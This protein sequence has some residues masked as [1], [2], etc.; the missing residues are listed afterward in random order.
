M[1]HSQ[2][3]ST[4]LFI[5]RHAWLNLWDK[6]MTTGRINQVTTSLHSLFK[7]SNSTLTN[8]GLFPSTG[9]FRSEI[10]W[11]W[12]NSLRTTPPRESFINGSAH[13]NQPCHRSR[14]FHIH[15]SPSSALHGTED[16]GLRRRLPATS[17]WITSYKHSHGGSPSEWW[18]TGLAYIGKSSTAF[19]TFQA[20]VTKGQC[21]NDKGYI[22]IQIS[23]SW[24]IQAYLWIGSWASQPSRPYVYCM[25]SKIYTYEWRATW[26]QKLLSTSAE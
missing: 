1:S 2:F 19:T 13:Q 21:L 12:C 24:V 3:H 5:L 22:I 4:N 23:A 18:Q 15:F 7:G 14:T 8:D 10:E 17:L 11:I 25:H 6:H 16:H 20:R 9:C 26:Q